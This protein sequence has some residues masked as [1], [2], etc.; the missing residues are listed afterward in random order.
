MADISLYFDPKITS[1][2]ARCMWHLMCK[3]VLLRLKCL[4]KGPETWYSPPL[5]HDHIL[6]L[7]YIND[8]RR[9]LMRNPPIGISRIQARTELQLH[10]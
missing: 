7:Q 8:L 2:E 3:E 6:Q 9:K 1:E 5:V 10:Y 4:L